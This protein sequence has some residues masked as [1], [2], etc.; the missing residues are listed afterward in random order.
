VT[1]LRREERVLTAAE[2]DSRGPRRR[3]RELPDDAPWHALSTEE[4]LR[5]FGVAAHGL[6]ADE[7]TA[8]GEVFGLNRLP[9]AP[10]RSALVRLVAQF[11]NILIYVLLAAAVLT[12][13]LGHISDAMVILAVV[14]VNAGI[15]FLQEGRAENALDSIRKIVALNVSVLRDGRRVTQSADSL[16]PGDVVVI[17]AGD[18]VP[19]D[20]RLLRARH[21]TIDEAL[22]TGESSAVEKAASPVGEGAALGDRLSMAYSGTFVATGQG[23]GVVVATGAATELGRIGQLLHAVEPLRTPLT[24]QLDHFGT[25][26]TILILVVSVAIF[27]FA[28]GL[29]GYT[30]VDAF[31][32]V[33]GLAVAAIPEGLPATLTIALAIGVRRMASRH[34]IVRRLPAVET[35]GSV[36]VICSDKTGTLTQ[37]EM[38]V[39]DIAMADSDIAVTGLGY[40]PHGAFAVGDLEFDVSADLPLRQFALAALLCNDAD[41]RLEGTDWRIAGDAMEAALVTLAMKAAW[42]PDVA[43]RQYPRDDEIPFDAQHRFMATLHHDHVGDAFILIKG[44]PERVLAM[45][46]MERRRDGDAAIDREAWAQKAHRLAERGE[47][48]L[49]LAYKAVPADTRSLSFA[50]VDGDAV[51]LGLAGLLDPPREEAIEAVADCRA[52]GIR[53]VM[54]TGDHAATAQAIARQLGIGHSAKVLT[55]VDLDGFDDGQLRAAAAE[56]DVFA[57]TTPEHKLRLVTAL[58]SEGRVVA[59]TGDGVNDAPA[60][61]RADVGV[62][63]GRKG[64]EAAKEAAEIVLANDDFASIVAAVRE[65]RTVYDNLMKVIGWTLPTNGG[66]ALCILAALVLGF[67]L[68]MTP[69]Q[70]L[71]IN[72]VTA[73]T[74]GLTLAFERTEPGTMQ[75]PPRDALQPIMTGRLVWRIGFV[76]VLFLGG[77]FGIFFWAQARGLPLET[78]RTLVVNTLVVMEIAYLFSVRFTHG[79]SLTLRGV[80]GT[81]AVLVAVTVV[82]ALQL[83]FT[84][85]PPLQRVFETR[86]VTPAQGALVVLV[87]CTLLFLVEIEKRVFA[88]GRR[89]AALRSD[90]ALHS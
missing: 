37:N 80:A 33:V 77:A 66:E 16:V 40:A 63:M 34:A 69:I 15:G 90:D 4:V 5:A 25:R 50:D 2:D 68:P 28:V 7:A 43:R 49:A 85:A 61:K 21:L 47:R 55:G 26:L 52:A 60:L 30:L 78:G 27:A 64:T 24:R 20:L 88:P 46:S 70:I 74:L 35:L 57:R 56:A 8:R 48:L 19:A 22:L 9:E 38:T 75:K 81:P 67:A 13:L 6:S 58:Q 23:S 87:G 79:T 86:S 41:L 76:S 51:L 36:S 83:V 73:A 29:R 44:A 14:F 11:R 53:V 39:R 62:A 72:M 65:G 18:R 1:K 59:M 32:M 45:C 89:R 71:W 12:V 10:R 17:E 42:E 82:V 3:L 31:L 84:Y 54:I